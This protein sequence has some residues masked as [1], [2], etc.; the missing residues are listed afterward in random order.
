VIKIFKFGGASIKDAPSFQNVGRIVAENYTQA[1][2]QPENRLVLIVSALGK[3]TNALERVVNAY[4]AAQEGSE[5]TAA[6]ELLAEVR[7]N[8]EAIIGQLFPNGNDLLSQEINDLLI[9]IEWIIEEE[10]RPAYDYV[11]DQ[12]VSVGELLSTKI[13]A[14]VL[15]AQFDLPAH[16]LDARDMIRTDNNFR[17]ANVDWTSSQAAISQQINALPAKAIALSQGFIGST[18]DNFSTTLGREG[19][20]YTAAIFAYCL[21]AKSLT[22]WKDVAGVLTADPNVFGTHAQLL[23]K[24]SYQ[25]A[26]E[27]TYYGA[28]VIHPNTL[29]PLQNKQ[30]PLYV[31][32]FLQPENAGTTVAALADAPKNYPPII[33]VKKN[34]ALLN[35]SSLSFHFIDEARFAQLFSQLAQCRIKT[36][37]IQNT[38]L[39]FSIVVDYQE[40]RIAKFIALSQNLYKIEL[41]D[42]LK[43]ITLRYASPALEQEFSAQGQLYLSERIGQNTQLLMAAACG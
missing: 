32:S 14:A 6:F 13:L 19:S 16:W 28:Q 31:K 27:M 11:Y 34:Q 26:I 12:V 18:D 10:I 23:P 43:L 41:K 7:A 4:F 42:N 25:E 30:I 20:D 17:E 37:M 22:I 35:I 8:H 38:A 15:Q 39:A 29:R 40:D 5:N 2:D 24:I 33:V 9:D 36:N 1:F 21:D 3:T